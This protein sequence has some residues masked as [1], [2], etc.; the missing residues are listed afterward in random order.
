MIHGLTLI[1][2]CQLAGEGAARA[3]SLPVPGPVAGMGLML[4]L[5]ALAPPVR[6]VVVPVA[7]G[8]LRHLSLFFVPA[9]V[10][11]VA[12]LDRLGG[13][14]WALGVVI[15]ASTVLALVAGAL[16]FALV[17]RLTGNGPD[18]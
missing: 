10:G 5:L 1:L 12:H 15:V 9:G 6:G 3:L 7:E 8:M 4:G 2:V 14:A 11:V 17:A 18:D 16:A 13:Q